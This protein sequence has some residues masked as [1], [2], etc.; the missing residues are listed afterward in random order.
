MRYDFVFYVRDLS[1]DY[2]DFPGATYYDSE[3]H[4]FSINID[5]NDNIDINSLEGFGDYEEMS[6]I[7]SLSELKTYLFEHFD[8]IEEE[9][10]VIKKEVSNEELFK[11]LID[12][13]NENL[14]FKEVA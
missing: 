14:S 7:Q 4:G 3:K 10:P 8:E 5:Y 13:I 2:G 9:K 6:D 11:C 1:F 12:L